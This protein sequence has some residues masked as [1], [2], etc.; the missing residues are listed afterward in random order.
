MYNCKQNNSYYMLR[1]VKMRKLLLCMLFIVLM[2]TVGIAAAEEDKLAT[3]LTYEE[4]LEL[5]SEFEQQEDEALPRNVHPMVP[6]TFTNASD[7]LKRDQRITA[8]WGPSKTVYYDAGSYKPRK[9]NA[10]YAMWVEGD[11]VY[12]V[13]DY[14]SVGYRCVYFPVGA[15]NTTA[16]VTVVSLQPVAASVAYTYTPRL[17]PG[18]EYDEY[19]DARVHSGI[20]IS[21][22]IRQN[23]WVMIEVGTS[24]EGV[25]RAWLPE[26]C[27]VLAE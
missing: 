11:Y 8:Y 12:T 3:D 15:F 27:V 1:E 9:T 24:K 16:N 19:P 6:I 17:G 10:S 26:E 18:M 25:V 2:L 21:A 23:G 7:P 4:L 14:P 5:L 13:L 22:L 20:A